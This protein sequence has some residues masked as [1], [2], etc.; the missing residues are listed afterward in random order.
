VPPKPYRFCPQ[1][2]APLVEGMVDGRVRKHCTVC[3]FVRYENP[4]PVVV[5]IAVKGR[6][7][8]LIKRGIPPKKG[9]WGCPSGFVES[10]ETPEEACLR[11]LREEAGVT[12]TVDHLVRVVRREDEELYGDMLVVSYLVTVTGGEPVAGD[13]CDDARYYDPAEL[14]AY[15]AISLRDVVDEVRRRS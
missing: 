15:L 10:G 7:F 4:L 6:Q 1:C 9:L 5:A 3:G 11:E 8:L 2:S 13:E 14:P 12:G